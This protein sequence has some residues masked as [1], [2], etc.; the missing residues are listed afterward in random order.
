MASLKEIL[1]RYPMASGFTALLLFLHASLQRRTRALQRYRDRDLKP[2]M[3]QHPNGVSG[4]IVQ[5]NVKFCC[6]DICCK[7]AFQCLQIKQI[8]MPDHA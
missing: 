5:K 8:P 2:T 3:K 4:R 1:M 7:A 6:M